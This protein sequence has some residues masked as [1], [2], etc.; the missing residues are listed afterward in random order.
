MLHHKT[1]WWLLNNSSLTVCLNPV[2][3]TLECS[4]VSAV[5]NPPV[6]WLT[7]LPWSESAAPGCTRT[8][9]PVSLCLISLSS[10]ASVCVTCLKCFHRHTRLLLNNVLIRFVPNLCLF[11]LGN[12]NAPIWWITGPFHTCLV[13][14]FW[15][16]KFT[17]RLQVIIRSGKRKNNEIKWA[18]DFETTLEYCALNW[19]CW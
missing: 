19:C 7:A 12:H 13:R 3:S 15:L 2:F 16:F 10:D 18:V 4:R 6:A 5:I 1:C 11:L 14:I 9:L 8:R 17:G